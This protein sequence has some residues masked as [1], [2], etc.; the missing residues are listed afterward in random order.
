MHSILLSAVIQI[1][2]INNL[3]L[4]WRSFMPNPNQPDRNQQNRNAEQ[5]NANQRKR[6]EDENKNKQGK[7]GNNVEDEDAE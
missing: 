6:N 5:A 3:I 2:R 4:L 7:V 1:K